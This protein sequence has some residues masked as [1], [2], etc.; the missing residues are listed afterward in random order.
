MLN[1][2]NLKTKSICSLSKTFKKFSVL[3]MFKDKFPINYNPKVEE[4]NPD[5]NIKIS[6]GLKRLK[7]DKT[8][9]NDIINSYYNISLENRN[10]I[11]QVPQNAT[12]SLEDPVLLTGIVQCVANFPHMLNYYLKPENITK[13]TM[14]SVLTKC[15]LAKM[16]LS[17]VEVNY[18][19]V[20]NIYD[21]IKYIRILYDN[22]PELMNEPEIHEIIKNSFLDLKTFMNKGGSPKYEELLTLMEINYELV[23]IYDKMINAISDSSLNI[24]LDKQFLNLVKMFLVSSNNSKLEINK[25][26]VDLLKNYSISEDNPLID[27]KISIQNENFNNK[28]FFR[29]SSQILVNSNSSKIFKFFYLH[30]KINTLKPDYIFLSQFSHSSE[31]KVLLDKF[32]TNLNLTKDNFFRNNEEKTILFYLSLEKLSLLNKNIVR[33]IKYDFF[34]FESF[35]IL[36]KT[37]LSKSEYLNEIDMKS[38]DDMIVK[39]RNRRGW[40]EGFSMKKTIL[41]RD[42][43]DWYIR[44]GVGFINF[45]NQVGSIQFLSKKKIY[46][47]LFKILENIPIVNK[48]DEIIHISYFISTYLADPDKEFGYIAE[49]SFDIEDI[50]PNLLN[51]FLDSVDF[52]VK[53]SIRYDHE[54]HILNKFKKNY[55][56]PYNN[57]LDKVIIYIAKQFMYKIA[58]EKESDAPMPIELFS[59]CLK[60][61]KIL[62]KNDMINP[63]YKINENVIQGLKPFINNCILRGS[64]YIKYMTTQNLDLI[65]TITQLLPHI[66]YYS[67]H[68]SNPNDQINYDSFVLNLIKQDFNKIEDKLRIV[69]NISEY[70]ILEKLRTKDGEVPT[71][72]SDI[73][74]Y[75]YKHMENVLLPNDETPSSEMSKLNMKKINESKFFESKIPTLLVNLYNIFSLDKEKYAFI[76]H[77]LSNYIKERKGLR[78]LRGYELL[79]IKKDLMNENSL[80][81]ILSN[82]QTIQI[83]KNKSKDNLITYIINEDNLKKYLDDIINALSQF[84]LQG[85]KDK[86]MPKLNSNTIY[87]QFNF[88][89]F[90]YL[91]AN[92]FESFSNEEL[93]KIF[94]ILGNKKVENYHPLFIKNIINRFSDRELLFT[95]M[96]KKE[97]EFFNLALNWPLFI[98]NEELIR[99]ILYCHQSKLLQFSRYE[100]VTV[101]TH[102]RINHTKLF[103]FFGTS[104]KKIKNLAMR[105]KILCDYVHNCTYIGYKVELGLYEE[106]LNNYSAIVKPDQGGKAPPAFTNNELTDIIVLGIISN[107]LD[108]SLTKENQ[109]VYFSILNQINKNLVNKLVLKIDKNT[110]VS[111]YPSIP[112]DERYFQK[113]LSNMTNKETIFDTSNDNEVEKPEEEGAGYL[114]KTGEGFFAIDMEFENYFMKKRELMYGHQVYLNDNMVVRDIMKKWLVS[115]LYGIHLDDEYLENQL[116]QIFTLLKKTSKNNPDYEKFYLKLLSY[117]F[118]YN[119]IIESDFKDVITGLK[120]DFLVEYENK[121][122]F[123]VVVPE[124][125]TSI[126][127]EDNKQ[128]PD[129]VYTLFFECIRRL[130]DVTFIPVLQSSLASMTEADYHYIILDKILNKF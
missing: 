82:F 108:T 130:Q 32:L 80:F 49:K 74:T 67:I 40:I 83:I 6:K 100:I 101:L 62:F 21:M 4:I 89:S 60:S 13:E 63:N 103:S 92:I 16:L 68:N 94:K 45:H 70:L 42:T 122:F 58:N 124:E 23:L 119:F 96:K 128:H 29:S 56:V 110:E 35:H 25:L 116:E 87:S 47:F 7:S 54:I 53:Y 76:L 85:E 69:T 98:K 117:A 24:T 125:F 97:E 1:L 2:K 106:I 20:L 104:I 19:Q 78:S 17:Q 30:S 120:I 59:A 79:K 88:S 9:T 33:N 41:M 84:N 107:I 37:L 18:S 109:Q 61:L 77:L 15:S 99:A 93:I 91:V 46:D 71:I 57:N 12:I 10:L 75:V 66:K 48:P 114:R 86:N 64:K 22:Y 3:E 95:M 31:S 129:G 14:L 5:R 90:S 111:Y 28:S 72:Y 121:Q 44:N 112:S 27:S 8:F 73:V 126:D 26:M 39:S 65:D 105:K 11:N 50:S 34:R 102:N 113:S 115:K 55:F 51:K 36:F 127:I 52:R 43:V 118:Q 38:I 81:Q 123:I